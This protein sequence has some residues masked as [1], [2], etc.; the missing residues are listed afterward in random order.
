MSKIRKCPTCE[1]EISGDAV[2][3]LCLKCLGRLGFFS[4]AAGPGRG[5]PLRLGDYE[6]LEE[7]A[8]GGMGVVYRARQLSLN[9]IVAL[10]VVLH[11]PFS[12]PD[13]VRRFRNEAQV[14]AA[15]R[16]PNI[17]A[18][19]EVGEHNGNHFLSLEFVEGRSFAE[20]VRHGPLPARRAANYL[21]II[22]Q[23]M[24]H[25]HQRGVLHRDLKPS[26]ILLDLLDQPR[27]TDFGLAKLVSG[28][29]Q[30]T[31]TGQV[32]GSP[33]YMP[34]EQAAG[35][36]PDSTPQADI[37]SLGAILYELLTGRPPFQGETLQSVLAQVQSA[38]A[39]LP[40][41]LNP[42]TPVDLQTIC[43]KC[44][45][46][47][48]ARR[49]ASAR[50][51]AEDLGCFL[52]GKPILARPVSPQERAWLWCRRRPLLAAVSAGLVAA[53]ILGVAGIAWQWRRAEFHA[54]GESRQRL[55]AEQD[56]AR[57]RLNLYA[58]DVAVASQAVQ[59]GNLGLARRTLAG[60]R[61]KGGEADLRGFEWRYL[62]N[63]CRGDQLATLAGHERTVTCAA[64]SPE[65][66][67]LA[68]GSMDGTARI[69]E[70]M[71][72][73][74][75]A[76]LTLT[77]NTVWSVAFTPD[78]KNLVTGC[79]ERVEFWDTGSWQARTNFPGGMAVLS[80][81]GTFMA[82]AESSPPFWQPAGAVRLWNWRTGQLL[83][84][85]DQPGRALALSADGQ[86]LAIAG[87][88]SAITV[89][90]ATTGKRV[91]Q[92]PARS[93][94][95]ALNLSPDGRRL[96]AAGWSSEVSVLKLDGHSPP[97]ILSGH[98]LH[99]WSAVFSQDGA[100]IA[101]TS[102]DQRVRLWDAATLQPES[103]LRGHSGEVWCAAFSPD[104]KLLATGGK[105]QNVMLWPAAAAHPQNE[106]PHDTDFRPLF[107]PDGK[108]V[109]TV[110]PGS[111]HCTLW[112]ADGRAL[113]TPNLAGGRQ[114]VGFSSDGKCVA[115]FD[116][117]SLSLK[118]W[119]PQGVIPERQTA[120][121]GASAEKTQFVFTGMSPEQGFFFAI[122]AAGLIHLWSTDTGR[123]L[124]AIK[125]PA[126]PIRNAV[127]SPQGKHIAVCVERENV[128]RLYDCATGAERS[129][130]GHRDFVSGLAFS[131]EGS[132]LAT[133]SMD[134]TI[135]LWSAT[136]GETIASLPGHM[137]ETTDVAFSPD[138]RTLASLG[139]NESLKLWHLPTLREV[140]SEDEP[141]AGIWLRFSPDDR[142]L[143]VETGADKLRLLA[144]PA[145]E[146][147]NP[148]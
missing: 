27:V 23:A 52:E 98:Q 118:F 77:T 100:T 131:P 16:H 46:K 26:N 117:D 81:T 123:L 32:L 65:G 38:E 40:R 11:G 57:T 136:S 94:V 147:H 48:P 127:L 102:S 22:A 59:I 33:N 82:T 85:F 95:W 111:G 9:R 4:E 18:I 141:R 109:V 53:V 41:R 79:K 103:I 20:L 137:Q 92:W 21:R 76:T 132:T 35:K 36:F 19:Y 87:A 5:S 69:W 15:L 101:T 130:A 121:T 45:Q 13:F 47:E 12:S 115:T 64:F 30:L 116:S 29:S 60:L 112:N 74:C 43:L 96:L 10:K 107:S 129:L 120:L 146:G 75:L 78:G 119:R 70:V 71:T 143:A 97:Q 105:D 125:G 8:R 6:L 113:V 106:L 34:P 122:D 104:G 144:A 25:A 84:R 37:Y 49:Y 66:N 56:A 140:V 138:G 114:V 93:P 44:L 54:Q 139:Q 99:A 90:D 14:V 31:V 83:R 2:E 110:N 88:D 108:W 50:E 39:V 17:V 134:G 61:P 68:T 126:P 24:E 128:A 58:A 7:I 124:R 62:W 89:W 67:R 63:L 28:D 86:L 91:C 80:K 1:S 3:G 73:Q 145:E 135:R 42:G 148:P 133:G 51:L 55:L 72:H 142:A